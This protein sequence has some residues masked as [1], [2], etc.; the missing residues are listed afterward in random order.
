MVWVESGT[1]LTEASS[2]ECPS[3]CCRLQLMTKVRLSSSSR[4]VS[5]IAPSASGSFIS[6]SP[7]NAHTCDHEV[8]WICRASRYRLN[9]LAATD[10]R[11]TAAV[12]AT[13]KSPQYLVDEALSEY[14]S[15]LEARSA[16]GQ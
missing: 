13:G 9:L 8:P 14:L 16:A 5:P 11:L 12:E 10:E 2:S 6:P 1:S 4:A 3:L 7:R 15:R